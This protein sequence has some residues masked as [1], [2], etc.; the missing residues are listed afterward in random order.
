MTNKTLSFRASPDEV[1]FLEFVSEDLT[2]SM[3][4]R[5]SK[6]NVIKFAL[7]ALEEKLL[8]EGVMTSPILKKES[9]EA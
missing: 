9:P 1:A 4:F 8:S 3:G 6:S 7:Q 2:R 5:L